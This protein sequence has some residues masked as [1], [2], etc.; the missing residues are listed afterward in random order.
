MSRADSAYNDR[1]ILTADE[2]AMS[3]F[4]GDYSVNT[5]LDIA[6]RE[7]IGPETSEEEPDNS[8]SDDAQA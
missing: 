6:S 3:R 8:E 7:A 2:I 4:A 1:G 5:H